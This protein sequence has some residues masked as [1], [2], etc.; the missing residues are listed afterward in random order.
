M[1]ACKDALIACSEVTLESNL[2][3]VEWQLYQA[4]HN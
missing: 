3:A 2:W 1:Y 4:K